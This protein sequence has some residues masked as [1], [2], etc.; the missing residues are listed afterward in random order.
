MKKIYFDYNSTTPL[1]PRV[2]EVMKPLMDNGFGNPSSIHS[3]GNEAKATLD[4]SREKVAKFLGSKTSEIVFTCGGSESNNFAIKGVAWANINKGNHLITTSVE[5]AS[6]LEVFKFLGRF[7]FDVTYL[8]VD[9]YGLIDLDQLVDSISDKT[10]L[11]SCMY[12]NNETGVINPIIEIGEI[13]RQK[14]IIF[15]TDAVQAAGKI[16]LS[17]KDMPVDLASVSSHKIYGP[18]GVGALYIKKGTQLES[19]V[20]GGGQ[21]RGK[22]SGTENVPGIFGFGKSCELAIEEQNEEI[23]RINELTKVLTDGILNN[24]KGTYINGH[25]EK[26]VSN[27]INVG[28]DDIEGDSL[29]MNLDLEGVAASTGSACSEGNVDP[30]HVLLAM[31]LNKEKAISSLRLSLGRFTKLEEINTFLEILPEVVNRIRELKE[32]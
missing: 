27:T 2:A 18:K 12:V 6:C 20:H 11:I 17:L 5:H 23:L 15:H 4:E 1:D 9:S 26:R 14:G 30:S 22:R 13:A 16:E 10:I 19:L 28:F 21:E 7:G 3:F 31:G 32:F 29:V 8:P 25:L 24:V